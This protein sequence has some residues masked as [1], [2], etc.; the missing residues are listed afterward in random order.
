M[1]IDARPAR[2]RAGARRAQRRR[3]ARRRRRGRRACDALAALLVVPARP[4]TSTIRRAS[5]TDDPVDRA[6]DRAAAAVP[7]AVDRVVRRAH[8]RRRRARRATRSSSSAP[9]Y[10]PNLVTGLGA[11][12]RP[13]RSASSPT[14]PCSSAGTLDIEASREGGA[15]RAVVRR[16][17][18]S[19]SSRSS[20]RRGFE[21]GKR[22]RVARH[23]PPRRR[24]RARVRG[25]HRA[26]AVR[27]AAQG[28]RRR[29]HRDGLDAASATT[30]ASRGRA[31]RSR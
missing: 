15:V 6:C 12:R 19:R 13:R 14:S 8:R 17:S 7:G 24:A 5:S 30:A 21:P 18:T 2:R 9:A 10:A 22:P 23:D 11:A 4:T 29:V 1:P 26:A 31:P 20:T 25:G 28:V 27:R 16:A 3:G